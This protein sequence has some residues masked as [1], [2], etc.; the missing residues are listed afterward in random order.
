M[1]TLKDVAVECGLSLPT[2]SQ[3]F[4]KR[5]H[6]FSEETRTKVF[7]AAKRL[8]YKRHIGATNLAKGKTNTIF[9]VMQGLDRLATSDHIRAFIGFTDAAAHHKQQICIASLSGQNVSADDTIQTL[10]GE[11]ICDGVIFNIVMPEPVMDEIEELFNKEKLPILWLNTPRKLNAVC[12]DESRA[13]EFL[14]QKLLQN[15]HEHILYI[16]VSNGVH[17]SVTARPGF[18]QEHFTRLGGK[19]IKAIDNWG[20]PECFRKKLKAFFEK[21]GKTTAMVLYGETSLLPVFAVASEAGL[22]MPGGFPYAIFDTPID[23]SQLSIR[24]KH[25]GAAPDF[26]HLGRQAVDLLMERIND[27]R[28]LPSIFVEPLYAD[29]GSLKC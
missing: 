12:P 1:A 4:G 24:L 22:K 7:E 10:L 27:Y 17:F 25:T 11:K 2:V 16:G 8:G 3:I 21:P 13:A 9:V 28:N 20:R 26:R 23:S 6:L 19:S 14:A 18:L 15:G 29:T 5:S